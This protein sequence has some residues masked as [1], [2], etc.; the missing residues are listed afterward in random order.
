MSTALRYGDPD[1][2]GMSS[3][4]VRHVA[5]LAE[6]W[7]EEGA[8]KALVVIAARRGIIVLHQAFGKLGPEPDAPNLPRDAIFPLASISKSLTAAA[9]LILVDQGRLGLNRP[10]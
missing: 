10:V 7:V 3:N 6:C 9:V 4:R 1:E 5:R 2:A 8:A